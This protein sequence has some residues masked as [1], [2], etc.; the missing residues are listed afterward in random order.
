ML[1]LDIVHAAVRSIYEAAA[2]PDLWP[3]AL[4]A[5]AD[6]FGDIGTVLMW[7]RDDGGFGTIVSPDLEAAQADYMERWWQHDIRAARGVELWFR[8]GFDTATD[9]DVVSDDEVRQHPIYTEFLVPH[10][11]GWF[12]A[13]YVAPDP[14]VYAVISVQRRQTKPRFSDEELRRVAVLGRHVEQSLRLSIRLID[15]EFTARGLANALAAMSVGVFGL[16]RAGRITMMNTAARGQIGYGI[17]VIDNRFDLQYE[18]S[19]SIFKIAFSELVESENIPE[20]KKMLVH[21]LDD[22]EGAVVYLIPVGSAEMRAGALAAPTRVL[23]LVVPF[24]RGAPLDPSIVRDLLGLTLNEARVAA[25]V[26]CGLAPRAVAERLG[27]TE[28]TTRTVLK[29]VYSKT[30]ISRQNELAALLSGLNPK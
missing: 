11:L 9:R 3:A 17:Q 7:K 26:G 16:D 18:K 22:N 4:Q 15:A 14:H 8:G 10:G 2:S 20:P 5:I 19:R 13:T 29:R 23:V 28:E 30:G 12:A 6:C 24:G 27:I 21:G 1:E 25:L